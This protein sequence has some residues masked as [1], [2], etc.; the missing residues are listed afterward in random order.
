MIRKSTKLKSLFCAIDKNCIRASVGEMRNQ[1]VNEILMT[2]LFRLT[3]N[4][5]L[6]DTKMSP[7]HLRQILKLPEFNLKR[8]L[9]AQYDLKRETPLAYYIFITGVVKIDLT[10]VE[11]DYS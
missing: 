5:F 7:L 11:R 1:A 4:M 6:L 9:P 10:Q 3:S 8:N 2:S